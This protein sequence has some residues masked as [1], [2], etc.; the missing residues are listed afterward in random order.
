MRALRTEEDTGRMELVLAAP[1]GRGTTYLSALAAIAAGA[2]ILGIAEFAG[3]VLSGLPAGGSAELAL[4]TTSVVPV[5][6]GVGALASQLASTRRM[7]LELGGAAVGLFLALRVIADTSTQRRL[8]AVGDPARVG[9]GSA[10]VHRRPPPRPAAPRRGERVAAP[11][12]GTDRR[13][14]RHRHRRAPCA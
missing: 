10:P 9:R 3:L 11:V 8:A 14:T 12:G 5:F 4:A 7:A 2:V 13:R 6:A 1:V